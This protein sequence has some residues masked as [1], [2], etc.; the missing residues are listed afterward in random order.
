V[1]TDGV[2]R[3]G[4]LTET[5]IYVLEGD[6]LFDI[7]PTDFAPGDGTTGG[8][9]DDVY[10]YGTYGTPRPASTRVRTV[11]PWWSL[12]SW[13][14]TLLIMSS[15]DGRLLQWDP[16]V[17]P[18][19][20]A[21]AVVGAPVSNR[22]FVVTQQK[23]VILFGIG[24]VFNRFGWCSI[25]NILDWNFASVTNTAGF[26]DVEPAGFMQG[27]VVTKMGIVFGTVVGT[28]AIQFTGLPN[29]YSYNLIARD[30]SP[31]TAAS[32]VQASGQAFWYSDGSFW[33][34]DGNLVTPMPCTLLDWLLDT[35]DNDRAYVV[36]HGV[37][38]SSYPEIYWFFPAKGNVEC[39]RYIMY[40]YA[41]K[42]WAMGYMN[43]SAGCSST[44]I[45]RP[46]MC[47]PNTVYYHE[48]SNVYPGAAFLPFLKSSRIDLG[49]KDNLITINKI[50]SDLQDP[51][52]DIII[53]VIGVFDRNDDATPPVTKEAV[54]RPD[55]KYDVRVT[56]RDIYV[57]II[58]P[59]EEVTRWS[60]GSISMSYTNRG[61]R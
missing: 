28:Y 17:R 13:G 33:A 59:V 3:L 36:M 24:G 21:A 41:D 50:I 23:T 45:D 44:I 52:N 51:D 58:Q 37:N 30:I 38:I 25:D 35:I 42:T 32:M 16:S 8:Y 46:V 49:Q 20:K 7:T 12:D 61:R 22:G 60:F 5:N 9:G 14:E 29:V 56:A 11:G 6:V 18:V 27:A 57:Y 19:T 1:A 48:S 40:N 43:R 10:N 34:T 39:N 31:I 47:S 15:F 4:I 54:V 2:S 53:N 55:G 26:F